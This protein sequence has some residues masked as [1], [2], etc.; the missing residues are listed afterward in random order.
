MPN[1]Y[2]G[3]PFVSDYEKWQEQEAVQ[4]ER[5]IAE[6]QKSLATW[7]EKIASATS[8]PSIDYIHHTTGNLHEIAIRINVYA[9]QANNLRFPRVARIERNHVQ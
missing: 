7:L 6:L 8:R 5:N 4:C 3:E 9:M 1:P 2:P